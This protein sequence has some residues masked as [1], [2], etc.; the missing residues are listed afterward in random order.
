[1]IDLPRKTCLH[2]LSCV[3]I[4]H[5]EAV[6]QHSEFKTKTRFT[7]KCP[8]TNS[9]QK[10]QEKI[11]LILALCPGH[12]RH[13]NGAEP[14]SKRY[15]GNDLSCG[16]RYSVLQ[17]FGERRVQPSAWLHF[18][19]LFF[20]SFNMKFFQSTP[21][22]SKIWQCSGSGLSTGWLGHV[23]DCKSLDQTFARLQKQDQQQ[24]NS[25]FVQLL[26]LFG[27]QVGLYQ[28]DCK[29]KKYLVP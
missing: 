13:T 4:I 16:D 3:M 21:P 12:Q 2:H 20:K 19:T 11:G 25:F 6:F 9:R 22:P 15:G 7:R 29:G 1:M 14:A 23:N 28:P 26:L 24:T 27:P 17:V 5:Q 8:P 18:W 10:N